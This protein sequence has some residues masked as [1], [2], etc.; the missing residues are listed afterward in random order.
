MAIPATSKM[1][2]LALSTRL[3]SQKGNS[4]SLEYPGVSQPL[5]IGDCRI[6][7]DQKVTM[8]EIP[9]HTHQRNKRPQEHGCARTR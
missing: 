7:R 1:P 3:H 6:G 5:S 4:V 2:T 8:P 9:K